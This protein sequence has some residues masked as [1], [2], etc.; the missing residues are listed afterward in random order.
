MLCDGNAV[1]IFIFKRSNGSCMVTFAA[2]L[3]SSATKEENYTTPGL[4]EEDRT[5]VKYI[6]LND[7]PRSENSITTRLPSM[8][9]VQ[10][11]HTKVPGTK[12][13]F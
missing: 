12:K 4:M 11:R 3:P 8:S 2:L 9:C 1:V 10:A 6:F 5:V 13:R 7:G